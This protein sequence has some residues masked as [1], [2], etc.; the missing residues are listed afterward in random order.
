M[1]AKLIKVNDGNK[2]GGFYQLKD[3][4]GNVIEGNLSLKNCQAIERGYNLDELIIEEF[5]YDFDCPLFETLGITQKVHK[6]I[7]IGMLQG[8]L[9]KGFKKALEILDD[10][11]F[12]ESEVCRF[13]QI[14]NTMPGYYLDEK[15]VEEHLKHHH[16]NI[17]QTKWD[18]EIEMNS[19]PVDRAPNGWDI[20]PKLDSDDCLI[21]KIKQDV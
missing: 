4:D 18:V 7:L 5:P 6:S 10:R 17:Q 8:T 12:N 2:D 13:V 3:L 20:F 16:K 1:K 19:I 14:I 9:E 11:K 15:T 21:L